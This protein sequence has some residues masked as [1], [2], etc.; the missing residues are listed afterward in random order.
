[1]GFIIRD[2][3]G[4]RV[5]QNRNRFG[6]ADAVL[7]KVD[8][9]FARLVPFEAHSSS[10]RT[11]CAYVKLLP[12]NARARGCGDKRISASKSGC[13]AE[14]AAGAFS[15]SGFA[16]TREWATG[17]RPWFQGTARDAPYSQA[18]R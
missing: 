18:R 12:R 6:H 14:S 3:D 5:V 11:N 10:V 16:R 9:G 13:P 7:A 8:P 2:R 4:I 15:G 17:S 1:M